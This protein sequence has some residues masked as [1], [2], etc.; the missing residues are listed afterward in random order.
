MTNIPP[1]EPDENWKLLVQRAVVYDPEIPY[2]GNCY[3]PVDKLDKVA[4]RLRTVSL[5][6]VA[7]AQDGDKLRDLEDFFVNKFGDST[8]YSVLFGKDKL[9]GIT[10]MVLPRS[11]PQKNVPRLLR[12][13]PFYP[14]L[15][16]ESATWVY[17]DSWNSNRR[18]PGP[19]LIA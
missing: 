3:L 9:N 15:S 17:E 1:Y 11:E 10:E 2:S 8:M 18:K 16:T 14:P 5:A 13:K 19:H 7:G 4:S 12:M 6:S